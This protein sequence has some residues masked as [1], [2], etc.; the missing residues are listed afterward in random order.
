MSKN[1]INTKEDGISIY[2]KDVRKYNVIS[3]QEEV[4]LAKRIQNG[5]TKAVEELCK[6]NLRFVLTIAKDYQNQGVSIGDLINE[7][8]YGLIVAANKFDHT[9]G[10]RF[11]SYAVHWVKQS[12]LQCL[13]ENSR[14]VRLP[15]NV[16][17]KLNDI[18]K[19]REQFQKDNQRDPLFNEIDYIA[20]PNCSSLHDYINEDGDEV[21]DIISD[22]MFD[23]PDIVDDEQE[24]IRKKLDEAMAELSDREK[25]IVKMYFGM[26]GEE[27]TLEAIGDE[28]DLTKER[29]RQIKE[30]AI[31]KIR[32]NIGDLI[33]YL[34]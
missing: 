32:N 16:V 31:R 8:N 10:F 4:E 17:N 23:S 12:I 26:Y 3:P 18:K 15:T 34:N 11:I 20:V 5:D 7:G 25:E 22:N 29:I 13:N 28:Y 19:E 9:K 24:I 1:F 14:T 30:K 27:M 2:L 21:V 33:H 6:A